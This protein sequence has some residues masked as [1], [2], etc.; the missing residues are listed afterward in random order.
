LRVLRNTVAGVILLLCLPALTY[1]QNLVVNPDFVSDLS[2]WTVTPLDSNA[3][4][5]FNSADGSPAAGSA[6]L[7]AIDSDVILSQCVDAFGPPPWVFGGRL[8]IL[9]M[10]LHTQ[11]QM[12]MRFHNR[13]CGVTSTQGSGASATA[14][15]TVG[16]V[17]GSFT[18]YSGQ[19]NSDPMPGGSP[20]VS[21]SIEI[22][23][24]G[25]DPGATIDLNADKLYLGSVGPIY[26]A[27]VESSEGGA[28]ADCLRFDQPSGL[29]F[30][31]ALGD[32]LTYDYGNLGRNHRRFLAVSHSD[33]FEIMLDGGETD[34]GRLVADGVSDDGITFKIR[35]RRVSTCALPI[36]AGANPYR[37]GSPAANARRPEAIPPGAIYAVDVLVEGGGE[38]TDCFRFDQPSAG[39]LVV[40]GLIV[41]GIPSMVY[42][43]AN[44]GGRRSTFLAITDSDAFEIMFA[45]GE[46]NP[47]R[48]RAEAIQEDG[49]TYKLHGRRVSA[50]TPS[51]AGS[52][53]R[54]Y[55]TK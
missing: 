31:D 54:P 45:G 37:R 22:E 8:R 33:S 49:L 12:T 51:F 9:T 46:T 39:R 27:N 55:I 13:P 34:T 5:T 1:A 29:L 30:L 35:G 40:D 7:T 44:L 15:A 11:L 38:F 53:A 6:Q 17:Q 50:C 28:F 41:E 52:T 24:Q 48:L 26:A 2:G 4:V 23:V 47:G 21:V 19:V 43:H 14:G 42:D 25:T 32:S 18:Q 36:V 20:S 10:T 16:G 3:T